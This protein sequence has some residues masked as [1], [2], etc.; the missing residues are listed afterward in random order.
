MNSVKVIASVI[1]LGLVGCGNPQPYQSKLDPL[2]LQ[3]MQTQEFETSK[4]IL[5]ASVISVF[6][7]TGFT[8]DAADLETG[9]ITA[10]SATQSDRSFWSGTTYAVA[11]KAS[12]FVEESRPNYARTRLNFVQLNESKGYYGGGGSND[13][14]VEDA[15]YYERIFQKIREAVFLREANKA[16]PARQPSAP[17]PAAPPAGNGTNSK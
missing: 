4:K 14:P 3:Q 11:T 15:A 5:F 10:K 1:M 12:A 9:V 17:Q 7:D 13:I 2:A 8:I 6:Q 16:I